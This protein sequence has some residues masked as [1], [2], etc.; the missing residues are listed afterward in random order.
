MFS[1]PLFDQYTQNANHIA[2]LVFIM[3]YI[4]N[5]IRLS[6]SDGEGDVYRDGR[7][8]MDASGYF[9]FPAAASACLRSSAIGQT[10]SMSGFNN[11]IAN[12]P[13]LCFSRIMAAASSLALWNSVPDIVVL[14]FC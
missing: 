5:Q 13:F 8:G 9:F 1:S 14:L 3:A 7:I 2:C 4:S 6:I 12:P 11:R 10:V